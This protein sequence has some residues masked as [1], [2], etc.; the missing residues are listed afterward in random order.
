MSI[1][2]NELTWTKNAIEH[3]DLGQNPAETLGRVAK[4]YKYLGCK[5]SEI[6]KHV[7]EFLLRCDPYAS[8]VLWA[9]T[10]ESSVKYGMKHPLI[11]IDKITITDPEMLQIKSIKG[12]QAQ[13]LAFT[14]LCIAKY[15]LAVAPKTD[16]WVNT[17]ESDIMKMA[18]I[19]TSYKRQNLLYGQLIDAGMLQSSKRITNLNVRVLYIKDGD[20]ALEITDY[21][22]LGNQYMRFIGKPF[23]TCQNCGL[24]V[25][26]PDGASLGKMKYC[27]DCAEK[28]YIRQTVNSVMRKRILSKA[29]EYAD[30]ACSEKK[31]NITGQT[32]AYAK[33]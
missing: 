5:K 17:P 11:M 32:A 14:L 12:V 1:I 30:G 24:T 16:G 4:Y 10:I 3:Y 19:N 6:R 8:V 15:M 9:D 27:P 13:R 28:V 29:K 26:A 25:K 21:R 33:V 22:N 31:P 7:E 2:L 20:T 23:F 18:N